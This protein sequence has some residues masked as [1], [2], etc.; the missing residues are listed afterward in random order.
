MK[1]ALL[2]KDHNVEFE[3]YF[4]KLFIFSDLK[5]SSS[6]LNIL[7]INFNSIL[8]LLHYLEKH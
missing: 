3:K 5:Y 6:I 4:C 8:E 7:L 1:I 2:I